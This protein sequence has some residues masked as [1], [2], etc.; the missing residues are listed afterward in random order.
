M[1]INV[2]KAR[3]AGYTHLLKKFELTGIP[4]W[5]VSY[6]LTAGGHRL[7]EVQED[8]VKDVF[9]AE[10]WPGDKVGDHLEFALKYDGVNLSLLKRIFEAAPQIEIVDCIKSKPS[11]KY[12]RRLWFF[13]EF[14]MD[15]ELPIAD[16]SVGNYVEALEP[17]QYY[18]LHSGDKSPRHRVVNNLLG[19]KAFCPIVRKTDKLAKMESADLGKRSE[20]ILKSYPSD[21]L[22]HALS[23]LYKKETK[24]SFEIEHVKPS[25]AR[26]EKFM[27]LLVL[28]K[29]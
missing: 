16:M 11:G 12:A 29:C 15:K 28:L 6:I 8:C 1:E 25:L 21:L 18:T 5:H 23:Y 24:S 19:T 17:K 4:N 10:Y 20:A 7:K 27:R 22:R 14:L 9:R 2:S 26:T 3:D 13:Y